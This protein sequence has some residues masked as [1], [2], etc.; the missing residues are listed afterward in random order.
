ME[1]EVV[2]PI[3]RP[4]TSP[5]DRTDVLLDLVV[6]LTDQLRRLKALLIEQGIRVPDD[7]GTLGS[8]S[9]EAFDRLTEESLRLAEARSCEE[10]S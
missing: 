10:D 2:D 1:E 9:D 8:P 7:L 4:R 6:Y 3:T 5:E